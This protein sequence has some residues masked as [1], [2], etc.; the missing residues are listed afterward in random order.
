MLTLKA[1]QMTRSELSFSPN[2]RVNHSMEIIFF[3]LEINK[4]TFVLV[5]VWC[6][7]ATDDYSFNILTLKRDNLSCRPWLFPIFSFQK[8]SPPLHKSS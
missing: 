7:I 3:Y 2:T 4:N 8:N 5:E 6:K 1:K